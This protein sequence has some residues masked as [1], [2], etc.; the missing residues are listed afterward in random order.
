MSEPPQEPVVIE[1]AKY[2][3]ARKKLREDPIVQLMAEEIAVELSSPE[4]RE[5]FIHPNS[6]KP[7]FNFMTVANRE[8]TKRGGKRITHIG[9]VAE[10]ILELI[11][12]MPKDPDA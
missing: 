6:G 10:A 8:Y 12:K 3:E 5:V 7:T 2:A 4:N 9:G 1:S 11:E